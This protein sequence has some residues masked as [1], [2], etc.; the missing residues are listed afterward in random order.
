MQKP[1][2]YIHRQAMVLAK[3]KERKKMN[4]SELF[5]AAHKLVKSVIKSGDNYRVT[6]GAAIKAI[7]SGLVATTKSI[8]DRLLEVGAKVWEKDA[9]KR[10]YISNDIAFKMGFGINFNDKKHKLFFDL[11]TNRFDG[12][13]KTFVQALNAK[14]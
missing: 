2:L 4:K 3:L 5:K 11:N 1:L 7:L 9:M 8:A 14:I 10:I 6:F 13:S 12:T